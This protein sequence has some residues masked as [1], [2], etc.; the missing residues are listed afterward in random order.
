[1]KERALTKRNKLLLPLN[2]EYDHSLSL[3]W[4]IRRGFKQSV[5]PERIKAYTDWFFKNNLAPHFAMEEDFIFP[6]LGKNNSLVKKALTDHRRLT[7]LFED[8]LD[9]ERSLS[10]IEEEL[11]RHMRFEKQKLLTEIQ[12]TASAKELDLIMKIYSESMQYEDWGD[13][14]W[15]IQ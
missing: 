8:R 7:R 5:P 3:C 1:M 10:L 9:I 14:F 11:E 15:E 6:L 12:K 2:R 13:P 4:K